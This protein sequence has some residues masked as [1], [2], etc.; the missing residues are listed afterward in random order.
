MQERF[1]KAARNAGWNAARTGAPYDE[2]PF[3]HGP[4]RSFGDQWIAGWRQR[5]DEQLED[6]SA[7]PEHDG[8]HL[9][10]R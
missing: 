8:V 1:E 4:M 9:A 2:N 7:H 3:L 6:G 10:Q 5:M